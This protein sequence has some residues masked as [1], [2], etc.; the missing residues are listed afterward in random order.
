MLHF[1]WETMIDSV[2]R[3]YYDAMAGIETAIRRHAPTLAATSEPEP[4]RD[5]IRKSVDAVNDEFTRALDE[6]REAAE[7]LL[8]QMKEE[9]EDNG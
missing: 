8:R 9:G 1:L 4:F 6:S 2:K 5:L 3:K 7:E